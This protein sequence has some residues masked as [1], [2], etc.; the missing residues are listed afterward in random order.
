MKIKPV[1]LAALLIGISVFAQ[2]GTLSDLNFEVFTFKNNSIRAIEVLNDST[3]WFAGSGGKYGRITKT[4]I[5]MDSVAFESKYLNFRAIAS[6]GKDIFFLSIENPAVLYKISANTSFT[7][8]P[9][10]VYQENH[11]LVFYDAMTFFDQN[12]GIAMGDPTGNCLSVI[13]TRDGG[14]SWKKISCDKLPE[15]FPGEA[16]FAAS[17][18]NI[19]VFE[20]QAWMVTGG[21]KAR[22]FYSADQ[23]E[24]W[25]AYP[26]PITQGGK[27][28]G[29]YSVAFYETQNG[30]IMGGDWENKK[31]TLATKAITGDGGKTWKLI[32]NGEIPGYI[33]CVQYVPG[34][35]GKEIAAVST[36]GIYY[37][38]DAGETWKKI[39]EDGYFSIR[40]ANKK[41]AWL[42]G[43][44]KI[45]KLKFN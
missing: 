34:T 29:I 44:N 42:S 19:T 45:A 36:E 1:F 25:A 16:A 35:Y 17:N 13:V 23:G 10:V 27:M 14:N 4:G 22:V 26:T 20:N 30:I 39:S 8:K 7:E 40:F 15:I 2:Q 3:V 33:S 18:S 38:K 21:A 9:M 43:N 6:N 32:A 5:E 12:N 24:T 31:D 37:S 11:E 41:T 28:T